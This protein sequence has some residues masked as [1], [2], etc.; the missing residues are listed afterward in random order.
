[1]AELR[2]RRAP[3][4]VHLTGRWYQGLGAIVLMIGLGA[5]QFASLRA[6]AAVTTVAFVGL[7]FLGL[8][9]LL[10]VVGHHLIHGR[11]WAWRLG[12]VVAG[13][14]LVFLIYAVAGLQH[15]LGQRVTVTAVTAILFGVPLV[16]LGL[17]SSRRFFASR[18]P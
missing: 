2:A 8:S 6:R 4:V 10:F 16:G 12:V 15:P 13:V 14:L 7:A 5:V 18:E 17:P 1:M 9:A 11:R 3:L